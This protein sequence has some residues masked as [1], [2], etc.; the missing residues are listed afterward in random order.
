MLTVV[1][2]VV[3][4]VILYYYHLSLFKEAWGMRPELRCTTNTGV[5]RHIPFLL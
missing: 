1:V 5:L 4:C 3:G 2:V